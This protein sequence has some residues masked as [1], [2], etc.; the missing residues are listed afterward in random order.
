[1]T[2][3]AVNPAALRV[4][5]SHASADA[6]APRAPP[7]PPKSSGRAAADDTLVS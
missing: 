6:G 1:M 7:T 3:E 5:S 2:S 4:G